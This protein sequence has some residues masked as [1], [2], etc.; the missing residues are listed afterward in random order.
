MVQ[1][2]NCLCF[3][4]GLCGKQHKHQLGELN[5]LYY[6]INPYLTPKLLLYWVRKVFALYDFI[7]SFYAGLILLKKNISKNLN[8]S[9]H[10]RRVFI[11]DSIRAFLILVIINFPNFC[12]K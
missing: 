10:F 8:V 11:I 7:N 3:L 6:L 9:G 1:C 5:I 4:L 12:R 2:F